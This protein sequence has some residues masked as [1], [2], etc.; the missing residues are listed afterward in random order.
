M[1][2]WVN[3]SSADLRNR[4]CTPD[5]ATCYDKLQKMTN[6][7]VDWFPYKRDA[8]KGVLPIQLQRQT[9][10]IYA[11]VYTICFENIAKHLVDI[12]WEQLGLQ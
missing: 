3:V 9:W 7:D 11:K 6:E 10:M 12:C 2:G 8:L 1:L 4:S 5:L